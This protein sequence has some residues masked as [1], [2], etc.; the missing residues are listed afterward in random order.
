MHKNPW[1]DT[2]EHPVTMTALLGTTGSLRTPQRLHDLGRLRA[3]A[4]ARGPREDHHLAV[5]RARL[6]DP[7]GREGARRLGGVEATRPDDSSGDEG[8]HIV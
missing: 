7:E 5:L 2:H 1:N 4:G 6:L 8:G 3:L